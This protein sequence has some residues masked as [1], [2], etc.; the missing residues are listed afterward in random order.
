VRRVIDLK[1]YH[2]RSSQLQLVLQLAENLPKTSFDGHQIEQV[3]LNLFNNAEQAVTSFKRSGRIVVRTGVEA[4][5]VWFEVEDDGPG[6]RAADRDRIFDPFFT[7]KELGEGTGLGLAVSYGI[8]RQHAGTIE[9]RPATG[10][11][12]ACFRFALPIVQE[13]ETA[14]LELPV[15]DALVE[16]LRGCRVL[17]AEDEPIVLELFARVL[18]DA[19]AK[20]TLARDG[21]EAWA[22]LHDQSFDLVVTDLRMPRLSGQELYERAVEERPELLRRFVF[23]TGDLVRQETVQFLERLPN[24]I[25]MKPLQLETVRRV[26]CQ[27]LTQA[28]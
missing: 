17:V 3:M 6:V 7:T 26:L 20:V 9:L 28:A 22:L 14:E 1:S 11:G 5:Q 16:Q 21:E 23:A 2:L 4:E 25:L 12:G 15:D 27:A 8:V 13:P 10:E 19:G 24:R 18:N